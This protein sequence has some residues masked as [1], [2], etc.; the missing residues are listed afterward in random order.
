MYSEYSHSVNTMSQVYSFINRGW[1]IM[2]FWHQSKMSQVAISHTIFGVGSFLAEWT[3][4][5]VDLAQYCP[6]IVRVGFSGDACF[7][8]KQAPLRWP[9]FAQCALVEYEPTS[10][11][12]LNAIYRWSEAPSTIKKTLSL[13]T[14][15][16]E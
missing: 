7:S 14:Q 8:I 4:S 1:H 16:K 2:P 11:N 9:L 5:H 3:L 13:Y 12:E 15:Q 6:S 10:A